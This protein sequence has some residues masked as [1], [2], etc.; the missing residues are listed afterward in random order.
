M[1]VL[2]R[3]VVDEGER[4]HAEPDTITVLTSLVALQATATCSSVS[5][6]LYGL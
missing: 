4:V 6:G 3:M 5:H 1:P 2:V